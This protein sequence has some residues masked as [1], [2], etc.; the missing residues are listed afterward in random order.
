[1]RNIANQMAGEIGQ[2]L[3]NGTQSAA[4]ISSSASTFAADIIQAMQS[5]GS[6]TATPNAL[7]TSA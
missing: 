6:T 5:Y 1:M 2:S 4:G 3:Q 7:A